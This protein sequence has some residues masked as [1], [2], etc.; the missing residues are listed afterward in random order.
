MKKLAVLRSKKKSA[1]G[2]SFQNMSAIMSSWHLFKYSLLQ[3]W[4]KPMI[5]KLSTA[6][7]LQC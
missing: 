2:T 4:V 6:V 7:L 5:V 1:L 3:G